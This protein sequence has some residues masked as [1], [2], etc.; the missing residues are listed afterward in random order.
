CRRGE[1]TL[2]L[3]FEE[4]PQQIVRNMRAIGVDLRPWVEQGLL[5]FVSSRPTSHGLETHLALI[6]RLVREFQ[7]TSVILDPVSNFADMGTDSESHKMLIRLVDY[8]KGEGITAFMTS[9]TS[10]GAA[11]EQTETAISSIVDTWLLVKAFEL[12][13]ERNRGLYVLKS[14]GMAHSNQVREFLI[15]SRG[16]ELQDVY[17][18]AGGVL[19]GSARA[20]QEAADKRALL[21]RDQEIRQK[22]RLLE[23]RRALHR[24]QLAKLEAEFEAETFELQSALTLLETADE[25][26]ALERASMATRRSADAVEPVDPRSGGK[27]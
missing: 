16:I 27:A 23:R 8:L 20:N 3:S 2:Y 13:G 5:R 1:R 19:T 22:R 10:G 12:N 21:L 24:E 18:G 26:I 17:V 6:H 14:R 25:Q 11:L 7:P 9:L 15:T 4:S